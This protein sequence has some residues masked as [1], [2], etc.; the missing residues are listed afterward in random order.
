MQIKYRVGSTISRPSFAC[1]C[2]SSAR[3]KEVHHHCPA[4]VL[5]LWRNPRELFWRK[6]FNL[7]SLTVQRFSPLF[8]WWE[9]WWHTG[10]HDA[11]DVAERSTSGSAGR[12]CCTRHSMNILDLKACPLVNHCLQ[13]CH[14][15]SNKATPPNSDSAY[16]PVGPFSS[17]LPKPRT[18]TWDDIQEIILLYISVYLSVCMCILCKPVSAETRKRCQVP[19]S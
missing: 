12:E 19:W 18:N 11:G 14:I 10:R 13:Q 3:I 15:Y 9:A 17:K 16:E 4:R 6:A 2:L 1:F 7:G 5:F 8:T